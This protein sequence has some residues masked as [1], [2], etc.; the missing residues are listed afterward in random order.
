MIN[1]EE[2]IKSIEKYK[3][4][5]ILRGLTQKQLI[6]V[7]DAMIKGGI[8]FV[9]ITFDQSG[10]ISNETTA[11]NIRALKNNFSD[12]AHIGAGTVMTEAQVEIAYKAGA[13]FIISPDC[14]ERVIH[15]TRE[16]GMISIPGAFTPTEV[17]N[18]YRFGADFVKLFPATSIGPAYIKA[19][20][21]PLSHIKLL[22]VG[23]INESNMSEYLKAGI[24][25]FGVGSCIV[26]KK[27]LDQNDWSGIT[28]LS[29]K[30]V[31]A[32]K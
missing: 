20:K 13:E 9:E 2:I 5:V 17:A 10:K 29:K 31:N 32:L 25:G 11:D 18:A 21:A 30:Y 7:V 26:N 4:V 24:S 14:D 28:E 8:K 15:K 6:D 3:I 19:I 12:K 27:M 22:A 16:L 23:G 1:R